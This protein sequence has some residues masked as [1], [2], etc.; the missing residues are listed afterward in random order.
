MKSN[1][2]DDF[3]PLYNIAI[4]I[5]FGP[6]LESINTTRM[7]KNKLTELLSKLKMFEV[8]T[9]LILECKERNDY[10]IFHS[11]AN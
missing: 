4:L 9:I 5:F 1:F 6:E 7:I 11:S 3:V 8:Q 2:S 10:K